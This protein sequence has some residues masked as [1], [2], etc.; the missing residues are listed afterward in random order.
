MI[1]VGFISLLLP[2][3]PKLP[4]Q[5]Y[6]NGPDNLGKLGHNEEIQPLIRGN[7]LLKEHCSRNRDVND[8]CTVFHHCR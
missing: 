7:E 8:V 6:S 5:C 1:N 3:L 4:G 2:R